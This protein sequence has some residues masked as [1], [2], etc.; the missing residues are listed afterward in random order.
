VTADAVH[1]ENRL[2]K[3]EEGQVAIRTQ[4]KDLGEALQKQVAGVG[5]DVKATQRALD[6]HVQSDEVWMHEHDLAHQKADGIAQ[7]QHEAY[8]WIDKAILRYLLPLI[9]LS[10]A[11]YEAFV[12]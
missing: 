1:L 12:R 2:T 9:A 8:G 11:L 7:G 6:K 3:L 4:I 10:L 5:S